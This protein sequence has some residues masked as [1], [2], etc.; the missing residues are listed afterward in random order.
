MK[1]FLLLIPLFLGGCVIFPHPRYVASEIEGRILSNGN[2]V[3]NATVI[4][5]TTVVSSGQERMQT[6]DTDAEGRFAWKRV[7]DFAV[8]ASIS[9][10]AYTYKYYVDYEGVQLLIWEGAKV[11][12]GD[13][14]ERESGDVQGKWIPG[15]DFFEVHDRSLGFTYDVIRDRKAGTSRAHR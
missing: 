14:G 6:A 8:I 9:T 13:L 12:A 2:P 11:D 15:K 10:W 7:T 1:A 5:K 4:R 3:T